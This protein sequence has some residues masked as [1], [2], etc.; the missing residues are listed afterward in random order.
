MSATSDVPEIALVLVADRLA[1]PVAVAAPADGSNRLFVVER[2]GRIRIVDSDGAVRDTPFL[3][4]TGIIQSSYLEQ[5]LLGLAFHPQYRK[6]GRF[7]V[8]YT[9][10][11]TNGDTFVAEYAVS[12]DDPN[13]A[14]PRSGRLLLAVDQPFVE[15]N[16]GTLGF[17]PAGFLYVGMGDGGHNGDPYDHAQDRTSLLG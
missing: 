13:V 9:D 8:A 12:R 14:D 1:E 7:F 15:H 11:R 4:R 6:N 16:G 2:F 10:F 17:G 3:D 5:G